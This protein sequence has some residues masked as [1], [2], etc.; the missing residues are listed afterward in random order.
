MSY[1]HII[2]EREREG[3]IAKLT[4]NRP[5]K[6]N[7]LIEAMS[8]ELMVGLQEIAADPEVIVMVLTGAGGNFCAGDDITEFPK[9]EI[10][11]TFPK[12]RLYQ[13]ISNFIEEMDK[14]TIAAVEG[15]AVGG[16]LELTMVC[17]LV[18]AEE[19]SFFGIPEIDIDTTPGYGG[20]QR[21][22]RLIGRRKV[23]EMLFLGNLFNAQ[24]A[25]EFQLVN[26][27][28][29]KDKLY[30]AVNDTVDIL[31]DKNPFTIKLAKF[32]IT[33]GVEADLKTALGFEALSSTI[34][35]AD[36]DQRKATVEFVER[37]AGWK[38]RRNRVK[39]WMKKYQGYN[40]GKT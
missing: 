37:G 5:T 20:T 26:Y 38:D 17:D 19:G 4:L 18:F 8:R 34:C 3:K 31:L 21:Y 15:Y 32:I 28:V 35:F 10:R 6:A 11:D 33:R 24:D 7:T 36:K 1:K 16:G 13:D 29:P 39:A 12:V 40:Y 2:V 23:K 30:E 22:A 14:I 25:K 27:V 9:M